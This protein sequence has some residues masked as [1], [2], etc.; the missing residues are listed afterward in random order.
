MKKHNNLSLLLVEDEI[1]HAESL[2]D[3]LKK[4]EFHPLTTEH[5]TS[6]DN[7]IK[8][9]NTES[10]DLTFLD[11]SLPES[12]GLDSY[13]K[14][15]SNFPEQPIIIL[16]NG[17]EEHIAIQCIKSGAR[18]YINKSALCENRISSIIRNTIEHKML[19]NEFRQNIKFQIIGRLT[20]GLVHDLRNHLTAMLGYTDMIKKELY[21]DSKLQRYTDTIKNAGNRAATLTKKIL[22]FVK[23]PETAISKVNIHEILEEVIS[24]INVNSL[25]Q[26]KKEF[27]APEYFVAGDSDLLQNAF[28]NIAVNA[29]DSIN[30]ERGSITFRTDTAMITS[31][32][33]KRISEELL[34]CTFMVISIIDNGEG[35]E[36]DILKHIFEPFF[37]TK[38]NQGSGLG[39][40]YVSRTIKNHSGFIEVTSK[41][42]DGCKFD[43]F[44]P[45]WN[46]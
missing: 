13:I 34:P 29:R 28:L 32:D 42:D 20:C 3:K 14:I 10:F 25:I 26:V 9:L 36:K 18:D 30:P 6:L 45:I 7:A 11:I 19:E 37:T 2:F 38:K 4:T 33:G 22:D 8:R 17:D 24:L 39:L 21:P 35:I 43:I 23:K 46:K 15:Q 41:K 40:T 31:A 1:H 16:T 44:L 12:D 5:E 27:K